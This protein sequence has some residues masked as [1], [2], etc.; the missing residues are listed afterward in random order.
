[1]IVDFFVIIK[2]AENNAALFPLIFETPGP[3]IFYS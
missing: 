1:M 2:S 3:D